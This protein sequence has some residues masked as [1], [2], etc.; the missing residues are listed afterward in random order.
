MT[1][2]NGTFALVQ[3]HQPDQTRPVVAARSDVPVRFDSWQEF[4][5]TLREDHTASL[6]IDRRPVFQRVALPMPVD[7]LFS[8]TISNGPVVGVIDFHGRPPFTVYYDDV[9][10]GSVSFESCNGWHPSSCPFDTTAPANQPPRIE[11]L[12][13]RTASVGEPLVV[14]VVATD[15][16]GNRLTYSFDAGAP[17]GATIEAA[18]GRVTWTPSQTD[19]NR[20]YRFV[21]R[22]TD[23]GSPALSMTSDFSV[24]VEPGPVATLDFQNGI[25][26]LPGTPDE[27]VRLRV[28]WTE[29]AAEYNNEIGVFV[30]DA[31]GRVG[32]ISAGTPGFSQAA[33]ASPERRIVFASGQ[34]AGASRELAFP[35]GSRLG[36]YLIQNDT[37]AAF[38]TSNPQNRLDA[39]PVGFFSQTPSNPD[40]FDHVL[41][42]DLGGGV[43]QLA[44]EDLV[45][46]G[47]R[48]FRDAV[49]TIRQIAGGEPPTHDAIPP[50]VEAVRL[51]TERRGR[52]QREVVVGVE[53]RFSEPLDPTCATN[54]SAYRIQRVARRPRNL[55]IG[56]VAY[57][58]ANRTVT[59]RLDQK[60]RL[61]QSYR[62]IG[63]AALLAD[64]AG[65]RLDGNADGIA[66]D[67]FVRRL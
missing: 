20:T 6:T 45:G 5:I 52:R 19:L 31:G 35:G 42:Q 11:P 44:W 21:V 4:E 34:G 54:L 55:T 1:V 51:L 16:D 13:D 38:L 46:G 56:S 64:V 63:R 8:G 47:D 67:D 65:N 62:V 9:Q 41:A 32:G 14:K 22:V 53:V 18:S 29:R 40:A 24:R 27:Q 48:N 28:D 58:V 49:L 15:V 61:G 50:T 12:S 33:I 25:L 3:R 37:T 59:L 2:D 43:W 66:G 7:W 17:P 60:Q 23:D 30:V 10:L 57:D 26:S 36:F 39:R